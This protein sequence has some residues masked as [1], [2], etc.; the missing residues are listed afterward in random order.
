LLTS[1]TVAENKTT[2]GTVGR[3]IR[4]LLA[5]CKHIGPFRVVLLSSYL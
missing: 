4:V 2:P 1:Q 3:R 5:T